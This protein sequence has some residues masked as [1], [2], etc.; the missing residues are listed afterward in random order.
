[1]VKPDAARNATEGNLQDPPA[2]AT[3]LD[4]A[5]ATC[6]GLSSDGQKAPILVELPEILGRY[7]KV[8]VLGS[9]GMGSVSHVRDLLLDRPVA[10]KVPNFNL[11]DDPQSLERF[12]REA[13]SAARLHHPNLCPVFD[14]GRI[15]GIV[16]FTMPLIEGQS[17]AAIIGRS[18]PPHV[19]WVL[20]CVRQIALALSA[21]HHEGVIHRDLKPSNIMINARD[22]PIVMDFGLARSINGEDA[23][24]TKPGSIL[25]T[26]AYMSPEQVKGDLESVNET[27]DIYSLGVILYE[28]LTGKQPF[29]GGSI[30]E[31]MGRIL[32]V[33]PEPLA[34]LQP[35]LDP[36]IAKLCG[37]AI[38]KKS[39]DRFQTMN[40]LA[41]ELTRIIEKLNSP[42][43]VG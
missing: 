11:D 43:G 23:R 6:N 27:T 1:M 37:K 33:E 5:F 35:Q 22:E 9:G 39:I 32:Y 19:F 36:A 20:T 3:P 15:D 26:P 42:G 13:R 29:T 34:S 14:V 17:L 10:L 16:Y 25:G 30:G 7:Q 18:K 40:H 41:S 8:R 2:H 24:L 31:V 12:Y 38:A 21:A 28:L 4:D